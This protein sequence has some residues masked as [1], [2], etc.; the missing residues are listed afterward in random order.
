MKKT[1]L[2]I[3]L[4]A[5]TTVVSF[6]QGTFNPVNGPTSRLRIDVNGNGAFDTG[7]D[8]NALASDGIKIGVFIGAAGQ[9]ATTQ[10]GTMTVGTTEGLM[11]GLPTLFAPSANGLDTAAGAQISLRFAVD[12]SV[13]GAWRGDSGSKTI[14]L[15]PASGP[16]TVVW[17]SS[18]TASRFGPLLVTVPEPSTIAL[19]VLGL[20]S[21]LLFRRR[22]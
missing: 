12:E 11:V 1:L 14:T 15:A 7:V 2:T 4:V 10:V 9:E 16:G 17:G 13:R 5:I 22:K 6:A 3:A 18:A 8:R 21:L 20:G 19:G